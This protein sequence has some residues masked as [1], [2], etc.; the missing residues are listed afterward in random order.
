MDPQNSSLEK[1]L[2]HVQQV[3]AQL[4][5]KSSLSELTLSLQPLLQTSDDGRSDSTDHAYTPSTTSEDDQ[6]DQVDQD[7]QDAQD[8]QNDQNDQ[9]NQNSPEPSTSTSTST[10]TANATATTTPSQPAPPTSTSSNSHENHYNHLQHLH[11]HQHQHQHQHHPSSPSN[12]HHPRA[13]SSNQPSI[14]SSPPPPSALT[15]P[16]VARNLS[17]LNTKR[18]SSPYTASP[19]IDYDGLSWP[20]IGARNRLEATPAEAR[21]RELR[22]ASA[23]RTILSELGEDPDREGLLETP[24]RYARAMLFF[25]KGYEDNVRD[26][27]NR[28]LFEEDHDEMVIVK[29]IDV[30]SLCEHHLVP[31][32]GKIHIGYIPNSKVLGLSKLARIAEMFARRLQVQER[33]TKQVAMA[34]WEILQPQGVAVV[35]EASHMCM[36]MRGVQKPGSSTT[37]SC[38]LGRF[39]ET[40]KTREEFLSLLRR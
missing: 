17:P 32:Y 12:L 20:S 5:F 6:V 11:Q 23:V 28:A 39:R 36:V 13:S 31:F 15:N 7:A 9:N 4:G 26:V 29:D 10:S 24:E 3:L 38:M 33:L 22:I 8:A 25:T 16:V 27:I 40:H 21:A 2:V 35:M 18:A 14:L 30:F 19:P 1:D 37:T 34:L